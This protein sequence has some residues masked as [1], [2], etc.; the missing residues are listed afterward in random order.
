VAGLNQPGGGGDFDP[1]K[2]DPAEGA[3]KTPAS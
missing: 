1:S 2:G 3:W